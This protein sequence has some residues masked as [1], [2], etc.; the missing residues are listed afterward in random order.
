MRLTCPHC[1]ERDS[2]EFSVRGGAIPE[3]PEGEWSEAWDAYLHL[4]ENPAGESREFWY[5]TPCG[6]WLIVTRN[7]ATHEVRGTV[8]AGEAG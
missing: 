5:H 7:T 1:G 8:P 4:R 2:R 6:A 3:R